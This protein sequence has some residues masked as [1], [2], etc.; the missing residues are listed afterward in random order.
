[1]ISL[2][3]P[4]KTRAWQLECGAYLRADLRR[5]LATLSHGIARSLSRRRL[6]LASLAT[7][8][9]L[10]P[11]I[12]A[13]GPSAPASN[14]SPRSIPPSRDSAPLLYKTESGNSWFHF[15]IIPVQEYAI[16]FLLQRVY[17][18][19]RSSRGE[20]ARRSCKRRPFWPSSR[21]PRRQSPLLLRSRQVGTVPFNIV[22]SAK[23]ILLK[24]IKY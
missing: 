18:A 2:S 13:R 14:S 7:L 17:R 15:G 20:R 19:V 4:D 11:R 9:P 16:S 21:R 8:R 1:M 5:I 22:C 24:D 23:D 12:V 3:R 6:P 10:R